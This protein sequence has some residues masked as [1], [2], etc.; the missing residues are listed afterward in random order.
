MPSSS[1]VCVRC[2]QFKSQALGACGSCGFTPN[3]EQEQAQS[4]ILSPCFDVGEQVIGLP[5]AE[6][7]QAAH[8]IQGG[9]EY[10]FDPKAV[11]E[12]VATHSA[13][14]AITARRLFIDLLRWLAPPLLLLAM[15]FWFLYRG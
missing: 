11:S 5:P 6:L 13:A 10:P 9:G 4:L 1:A 8:L 15:A 7:Q 3:T 12:V 14:R 2:G